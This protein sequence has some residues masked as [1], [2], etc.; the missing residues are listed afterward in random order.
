M[1]IYIILNK[2]YDLNCLKFYLKNIIIYIL[3]YDSFFLINLLII[4]YLFS[5]IFL[6]IK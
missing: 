1:K 3:L 5:K 6:K 4:L 2:F